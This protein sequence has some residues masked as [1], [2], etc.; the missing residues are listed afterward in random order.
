MSKL[1]TF[2][3]YSP[4]HELNS[5]SGLNLLEKSDQTLERNTM[6]LHSDLPCEHRHYKNEIC[7]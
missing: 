1:L 3:Q 4:L 7:F 2:A 6:N 5:V